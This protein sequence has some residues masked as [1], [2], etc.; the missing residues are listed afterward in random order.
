MA[1]ITESWEAIDFTAIFMYH[2]FFS[3]DFY[4]ISFVRSQLDTAV[5]WNDRLY[6]LHIYNVAMDAAQRRK[7]TNKSEPSLVETT[8]TIP[9][10]LLRNIGM[11]NML[12][13]AADVNL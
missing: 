7:S 13:Y 6:D 1:T 8:E 9:R 2:K 5:I 3:F 10:G 12:F 11:I 4:Q